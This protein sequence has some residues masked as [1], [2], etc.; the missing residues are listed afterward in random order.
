M[1][2]D[3]LKQ[4]VSIARRELDDI[5][6][7]WGCI[8]EEDII[9]AEERLRC[10]Q[11]D[12]LNYENFLEEEG[13]AE[14]DERLLEEELAYHEE[15]L[16]LAIVRQQQDLADCFLAMGYVEA[17]FGEEDCDGLWKEVQVT[18]GWLTQYASTIATN[19]CG[20]PF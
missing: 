15:Q 2:L 4:N 5:H 11:W 6:Q 19:C 17:V 8:S 1:R 13:E 16:Q 9:E 10:A 14:E 3:E 12:L 20:Q 18:Q 7:S